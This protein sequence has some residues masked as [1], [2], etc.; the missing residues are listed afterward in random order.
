MSFSRL[1]A[2]CVTFGTFSAVVQAEYDNNMV[3]NVASEVGYIDNF[4]YQ[5]RQEQSTAYYNLFSKLALTSKTQQSAFDFDAQVT[6]HFFDNFAQDDHIDFTLAPKYQFKFA[7]NQRV[8]M[9]ALWLNDYTYR[10]TGL[11]LGKAESLS[12]GDKSE[13]TGAK[14]GY[15]YGTRESQGKLNIVVAYHENA[16]KT[17]RAITSQLDT[18]IL[19]IESNFD[20]LLS[21]KTFLAFDLGYKTTKYPNNP[22]INRDSLTGLVGVKWYS[23]AISELEFLV[24]Y[25][26]LQFEDSR[27]S[28]DSAFKWRFDYTWRPSDF[29]QVHVVSNRKFDESYR[30][31]NSYRLAQ[32]HQLDLHHA[33]TDYLSVK[34]AIGFNHEK[35]ISPRSSQTED[36]VFSTLTLDYLYSDRVSVQLNYHYKSLDANADDIDFLY[37]KLGLSVKV[38]L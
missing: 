32:T 4:L 25:Q 12:E 27:L 33:F 23:T 5:D 16:F 9:S 10:G 24:G 19:S 14:L 38:E 36:Y 6:A 2:V 35:F 26:N 37:N 21:G 30:L 28:N 34:T 3:F 31:V 20:Y 7:Q 11:S 8:Y 29:T 22:L 1:I 13:S 18:E 15:E 17:R